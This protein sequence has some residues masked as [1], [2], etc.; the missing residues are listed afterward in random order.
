MTSDTTP[1]TAQPLKRVRVFDLE[2]TGIDTETA[3]IVTAFIADVIDDGTGGVAVDG[4]MD[5]LVNPGIEIPARATEVHGITTEHAAAHGIDPEQ[6]AVLLAASIA[7]AASQGIP[8]VVFNAPYDFTLLDR[9]LRRNGHAPLNMDGVGVIDPL[10]IDKHVDKFRRGKRTLEVMT[11]HYGIRLDDAHTARADAV[12]TG[13]LALL[14]M[15]HPLL[16]E[17]DAEARMDL[18]ARAYREQ[19]TSLEAFK[20][21]T[22]PE[23]ATAKDWPIRPA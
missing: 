20:R 1:T 7:E 21:R 3:R 17:L 4:E 11:G 18:Q 6:A 15:R 13:Q 9:E 22:D 12:A 19:M 10:V 14:L 5:L 2:T 23:F 16:L 8:V